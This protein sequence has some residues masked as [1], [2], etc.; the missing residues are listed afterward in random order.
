MSTNLHQV[1]DE[2]DIPTA[3]IEPFAGSP[4]TEEFA[5]G[6]FKP[7]LD[8]CFIMNADPASVPLDTRDGEMKRLIKL[9]H[10]DSKIH[11]EALSTEPAF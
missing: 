2:Q 11:V 8:I 10:P 7:S 5:L 4:T 1:T 6:A 3:V 9:Y